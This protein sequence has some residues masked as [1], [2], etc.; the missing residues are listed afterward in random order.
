MMK[1]M[2][3]TALALVTA[4]AAPP[5][6]E[7][8]TVSAAYVATGP[9]PVPARGAPEAYWEPAASCRIRETKTAQG[10]RLEAI[11]QADQ[12]VYGEYEFIITAYSSG[13][14][15]DITQ[16]GEVDLAAGER[17][18]VGSADIPRGRYRAILTLTDAGGV[19]CDLERRS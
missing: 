15:S 18:T 7:V 17:A 2:I 6:N 5:H 9:G 4:C 19:L 11:A 8:H 1:P 16:G 14:S 13:G 12:S 3:F 10:V